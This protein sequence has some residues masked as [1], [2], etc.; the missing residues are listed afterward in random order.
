VIFAGEVAD[1]ELEAQLERCEVFVAPSRYESF[2]LVFLEAMM[3]GK[4]VVGC[5]AGG[6]M[7]V[8]DEGVTGLLAEPGDS[9]SLAR[10]KLTERTLQFYEAV[11]DRA[12]VGC[13]GAAGACDLDEVVG[14]GLR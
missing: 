9:N 12:A 13:R 2:G 6:M 1:S 8:I 7:E 3:F 4:A 10:E 14:A 11:L 5:R